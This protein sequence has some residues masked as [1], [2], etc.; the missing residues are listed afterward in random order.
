MLPFV[1]ECRASV[2]SGMIADPIVTIGIPCYNGARWVRQ[3]VE[4]ALT[5]TLSEKEVLVINDGSTD[6]SLQ[7]LESFRGEIRLISTPNRGVNVARNSIIELARG[8]WIQY[9]DADDYLLPEKLTSQLTELNSSKKVDVIYSPVFLEYW[10]PCGALPLIKSVIDC[11]IDVYA[12]WFGWQLPQT[13]GSLWSK[14]FLEKLGGWN[15]DRDLICD[16]HELYMRA[17]QAEGSFQFVPI[18]NAVYRIWS[19]QTRAHRQPISLISNKS[20]LIQEMRAW[21]LQRDRWS[22]SHQSIAG[23]ACFEMCRTLARYDLSAAIRLFR[24]CQSLK[25]ITLSGPAAPA[26]YQG[27]YKILGFVGA[28]LLAKWSRRVAPPASLGK[29][30]T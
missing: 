1:D 21:L 5:Q 28:E 23:Q 22:A 29:W 8:A 20:R 9:L 18:A 24:H 16:E 4:S 6:E 11:S 25:L 17:L 3:A 19:D 15:P 12:Q 7:I 26:R 13:G 27:A 2:A 10:T 30:T 14:D